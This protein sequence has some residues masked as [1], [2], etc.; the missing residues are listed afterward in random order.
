MSFLRHSAPYGLAYEPGDEVASLFRRDNTGPAF[1]VGHAI[2]DAFRLMTFSF[3]F[4]GTVLKAALNLMAFTLISFL[5]VI[6]ENMDLA[7]NGKHYS[8]ALDAFLI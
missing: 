8:A 2:A 6:I 1:A 3:E 7:K 4:S 5:L